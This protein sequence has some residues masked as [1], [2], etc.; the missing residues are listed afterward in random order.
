MQLPGIQFSTDR[1]N[2]QPGPD[3]TSFTSDVTLA[4]FAAGPLLLT[5]DVVISLV[6]CGQCSTTTFK[7]PVELVMTVNE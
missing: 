7:V 5:A 3:K 2:V 1:S 6:S 4:S